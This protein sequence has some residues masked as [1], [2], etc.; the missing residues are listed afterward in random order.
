MNLPE[1]L[2]K[3][4]KIVLN[5]G[6]VEGMSFS[7]LSESIH[8]KFMEYYSKRVVARS[9][10]M[11][12]P[13]KLSSHKKKIDSKSKKILKEMKAACLKKIKGHYPAPK[14]GFEFETKAISDIVEAFDTS[15]KRW[16]TM[17]D[18]IGDAVKEAGTISMSLLDVDEDFDVLDSRVVN[19]IEKEG[20]ELAKSV[21]GTIKEEVRSILK[22]GV[23][24]GL[25]TTDIS[26]QIRKFFDESEAYKADRIARTEINFAQSRGS[27]EAYRQ[28]GVVRAKEFVASDDAC[29]DCAD[30][31]G[32]EFE[33][34]SDEIPLHP[35]CRCV[36]APITD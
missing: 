5:T 14:K 27:S 10:W 11:S 2:K 3:E 13:P 28:S 31:D 25:T 32:E 19:A 22:Q 34:D 23:S 7:I 9:R 29:E 6:I 24:D 21:T 8:E 26:K 12:I 1:S 33:L 36:W 4:L 20:L 16:Q 18:E 35:N 30:N 15:K 17:S